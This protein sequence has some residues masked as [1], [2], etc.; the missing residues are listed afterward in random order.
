[1]P[2]IQE[3]DARAEKRQGKTES[4]GKLVVKADHLS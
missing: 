2:E 4:A 3:T 1:M